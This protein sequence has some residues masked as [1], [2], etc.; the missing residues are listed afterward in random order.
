MQI[1]GAKSYQIFVFPA[2]LHVGVFSGAQPAHPQI[3]EDDLAAGVGDERPVVGRHC[4]TETR[5]AAPVLQFARQHLLRLVVV[6]P[7][8]EVDQV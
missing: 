2:Y 3:G 1:F 7:V 4:Q 8:A 6:L 5:L